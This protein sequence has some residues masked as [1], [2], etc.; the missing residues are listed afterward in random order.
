[1]GLESAKTKVDPAHENHCLINDDLFLMMGPVMN[2]ELRMALYQYV[3]ME[4]F[5]ILHNVVG[6]VIQKV[7]IFMIKKNEY[8][9]SFVGEFKQDSVESAFLVLCY[10]SL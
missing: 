3:I 1:M 5:E 10:R 8:F 9:D 4:I 7:L 6:A 2:E